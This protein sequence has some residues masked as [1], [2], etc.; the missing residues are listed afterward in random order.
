VWLRHLVRA[1]QSGLPTDPS[2]VAELGPGDSLGMGLATVLSGATRYIALDIKAHANPERNLKIFNELVELFRTRAR[3]PDDAEFP[4]VQ[5]KLADYA[6]PSH[7]LTPERLGAALAESRLGQIRAAIAGEPSPI[8]VAY[9]AP[10]NDPSTIE[11]GTVDFLISQAVLE[12][13]DDLDGT[14]GAIRTWMKPGASMSHSIDFWCHNLTRDWNG[15]WTLGDR[16][17][18]LVRGTRR[19]LLNR[20]PLSAHV[21]LLAKY[22][23]LPVNIER[24]RAGVSPSFRPAERFRGMS[25][26]DRATRGVFL[27]VKTPAD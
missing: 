15:H 21:A 12:H 23:F 1:G 17:W 26:E 8:S 20:Q 18:R 25:A 24:H 19:Y 7:I 4:G 3:I 13:V 6:F 22:Q 16:T 9:V 27:Q 11:R 10:W 2:C 14:Y 5:P